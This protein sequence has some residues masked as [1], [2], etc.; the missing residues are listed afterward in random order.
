MALSQLGKVSK[1]STIPFLTHSV[2][3]TRAGPCP[4]WRWPRGAA[5]HPARDGPAAEPRARCRPGRDIQPRNR[6]SLCRHRIPRANVR[7]WNLTR[8][9]K[10]CSLALAALCCH[11]PRWLGERCGAAARLVTAGTG[12]CRGETPQ[13]RDSRGGRANQP[14]GL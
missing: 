4:C 1:I 2:W 12:I 7:E 11:T 10:R 13:L 9:M 5:H 3:C 8:F 6:R 14:Q